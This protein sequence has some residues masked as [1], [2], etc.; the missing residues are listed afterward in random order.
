MDQQESRSEN[1]QTDNTIEGNEGKSPSRHVQESVYGGMNVILSAHEQ[2]NIAGR[3]G[4]GSF[5]DPS[6]RIIL[7][8]DGHKRELEDIGIKLAKKA[9]NYT[10]VSLIIKVLV[11]FL[12]AF[13]A[14]REV[15]NQ[16]LGVSNIANVIIYAIVGLLIATVTGLDAAFKWENRSAELRTLVTACRTTTR[17]ISSDLTTI[18]AA[19]TSKGNSSEKEL[20]KILNSLDSTLTEI[21]TKAASLGVDTTKYRDA[22]DPANRK[23]SDN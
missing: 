3:A 19:K 18:L 2:Y 14:T 13:I 10:I 9:Q 15:A 21:Q 4:A 5:S 12:G 6:E 8:I 16:I 20:T 11:I 23:L 7:S 22:V 1:K 17:K